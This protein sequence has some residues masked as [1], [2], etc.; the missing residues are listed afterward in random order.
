MPGKSSKGHEET[1]H[2]GSATAQVT[3]DHNK[4]QRWAEE[5]GGQPACVKGTGGKDDIGMLRI[6]FPGY[7]GEDSLQHIRWDEWFEK[8]E[9]RKLALLYQ[10][11]TAGGAKSNFNKIISRE[12]AEQSRKPR[13]AGGGR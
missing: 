12:T 8:F 3:T 9:E 6:D 4:I 11:Q 13:T 2:R 10:E 7:S 5:R 1:A